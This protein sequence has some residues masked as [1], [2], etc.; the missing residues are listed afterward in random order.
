[1]PKYLFVYRDR[2]DAEEPTPEQLQQFLPMWETWFQQFDKE[3]LDGGDG[4][5]PTGKVLQAD[6]VVTD[7][8]YVEAKEMLGGYS[9]IEANSYEDALVVAKACPI[10][11]VGGTIEIREFAGFT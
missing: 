11:Q 5:L 9:V 10:S 8:P 2:T 7:G 6:G 1:M 3:I 4:L